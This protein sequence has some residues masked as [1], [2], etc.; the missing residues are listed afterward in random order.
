MKKVLQKPDISGRLVN[1]TI[2]LREFD[3]EFHPKITIK[4]QALANLLVEFYNI[5]ENEEL[6][7]DD[8]WV[9]YVD[10]SSTQTSSGAGVV[11]VSPKGEEFEFAIK[12]AF[13]TTNNEAEYEAV[14]AVLCLAWE[15]GALKT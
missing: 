1:W 9:A 8:T 6:P 11:L 12:M 10:G 13:A 7:K 4:G 5:L 14:M 15:V 2:E 3:I